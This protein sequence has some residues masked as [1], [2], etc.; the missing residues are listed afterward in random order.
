MN[1]VVLT[2]NLTEPRVREDCNCSFE[3]NTVV[4]TLT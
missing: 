4:L 2:L 1:K 3:I